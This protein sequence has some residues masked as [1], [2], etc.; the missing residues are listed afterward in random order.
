MDIYILDKEFRTLTIL[1]GY[2]SLIWTDRYLDVGD[3]E[4]Y[5]PIGSEF[6]KYA[7]PG[8]YLW[9][10]DTD[11]MM[12][13]EDISIVTEVETGNHVSVIGR[14]LESILDRRI[15]WSKKIFTNTDPVNIILSLLGSEIESPSDT[16]RKISNFKH[17]EAPSNLPSRENVNLELHGE[18]VLEVISTLCDTSNIGFKV[19]LNDDNE[20]VFSL[21]Y[22]TDRSFNQELNPWIIFSS[23][24]DNLVDTNYQEQ[25]STYKNSI[26]VVG[27][28]DRETGYLPTQEYSLEDA[29]GLERRE[30]FYNAT[31]ISKT[32]ENN[33]PI[34]D[35]QYK[36]MLL[37]EAKKVLG[38]LKV[39]KVFEGGVET[40]MTFEFNKDY[41]LG[42]VVQIVTPTG[43]ES[44]ARITEVIRS[45]STSGID[46]VPTF[47]IIE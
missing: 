31:G 38:E 25:N 34:P 20:F 12:I 44:Q 28:E 32:D 18:T 30:T 15:V 9:N 23:A 6:L 14:S 8:Y 41:Y 19:V 39:L 1:D 5:T 42:D 13:I 22:G 40:H 45:F 16:K 2:E 21:Y 35:A 24:Y 11:K 3:F 26:L 29:V 4:I 10:S 37:D 17:L 27:D 36:A 43:V 47:S 33:N 46:T 7:I